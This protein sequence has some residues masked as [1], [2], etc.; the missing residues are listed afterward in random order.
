MALAC[1]TWRLQI[2]LLQQDGMEEVE[3]SKSQELKDFVAT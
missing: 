3:T 1:G 2:L